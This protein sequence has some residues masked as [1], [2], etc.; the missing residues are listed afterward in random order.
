MAIDE[1]VDIRPLIDKAPISGF[2]I[3]VLLLCTLIVVIDGYDGS[4][5]GFVGPALLKEVHVPPA[6]LGTIFASS[7]FGMLIGALALGYLADRV[8]RKAIMLTSIA[9]FGVFTLLTA[10]ATTANDFI[11]YRFLTGIG[12]GGCMPMVTTMSAEYLPA[13]LR[14]ALVTY[15]AL[16]FTVGAIIASFVAAGFLVSEG[17]T[18]MFWVGG[19]SSLLL[20]AL[21]WLALPELI[22]WLG[23]HGSNP[24]RLAQL[25][26]KTMP[27]YHAASGADFTYREEKATSATVAQ[28]FRGGRAIPTLLFWLV[29]TMNLL[30]VYFLGNW[31]TT[32]SHSAGFSIQVATLLTAVQSAGS[33]IGTLVIGVLISRYNGYVVLFVYY[34]GAALALA[35]LGYSGAATGPVMV[36][37]FFAGW[38]SIGSQY[39]VNTMAAIYYPTFMRSSG[40]GWALGVGR[41]GL[42]IGPMLGGIMLGAG[43]SIAMIWLISAIAP[44]IAALAVF[45]MRPLAVGT[46]S[47]DATV[48]AE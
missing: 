33:I 27:Q 9:F 13:R 4:A 2:Q 21:T 20:F 46:R 10:T 12:L 28:L 40:V 39:G 30:S 45:A 47:A 44:A 43:W 19:I 34:V 48:A 31:L 6:M 17:W 5:I 1:K 18:V 36:A 16:G 15:V 37:V 22:S 25:V 8:G 14:H 35:L 11:A 38:F 23:V 3:R 26:A 29:F 7:G 32:L 24:R 42:I 41:L